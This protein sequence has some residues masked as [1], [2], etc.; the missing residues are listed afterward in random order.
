MI[1]HIL[2]TLLNFLLMSINIF[3]SLFKILMYVKTIYYLHVGD[4]VETTLVDVVELEFPDDDNHT[5][6]LDTV[7]GVKVISI[8]I[9]YIYIIKYLYFHFFTIT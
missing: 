3:V 1:Y 5:G 7:D 9:K 8:S 6:E 4:D 2:F